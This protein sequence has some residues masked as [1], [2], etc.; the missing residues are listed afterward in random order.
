MGKADVERDTRFEMFKNFLQMRKAVFENVELR[1][2][3]CGGD[4]SR[5]NTGTTGCGYCGTPGHSEEKCWSKER[6]VGGQGQ[7]GGRGIPVGKGGC[8][9]CQSQEHWKNEC[10]HLGTIKD[11]KFVKKGGKSNSTRLSLVLG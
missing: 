11:K 1:G 6:N 7:T 2:S 10:P 5:E 9:I 3:K 4:S 8:D